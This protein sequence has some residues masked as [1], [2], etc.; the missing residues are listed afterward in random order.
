MLLSAGLLGISFCVGEPQQ[1]ANDLR[2]PSLWPL[3]FQNFVP[4]CSPA[5]EDS[6]P[7]RCLPG[8]VRLLLSAWLI[9]LLYGAGM[10][11][12]GKLRLVCEM[13]LP[14]SVSYPSR[15]E[16]PPAPPAL[17]AFQCL[18]IDTSIY[19]ICNTHMHHNLTQ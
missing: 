15:I 19:H 7:T 1:T 16:C 6:N 10:Y 13:K 2:F 8:P 18:Q 9:A 11:P 17:V 12:W 5:L 3:L 14:S 4:R